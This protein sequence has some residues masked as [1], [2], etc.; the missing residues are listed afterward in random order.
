MGQHSR[1]VFGT[2]LGLSGKEIDTLEQ[3]KIIGSHVAS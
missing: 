2:L 1:E 3:K